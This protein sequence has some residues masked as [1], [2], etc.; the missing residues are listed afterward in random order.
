[1]SLSAK[2]QRALKLI[3]SATHEDIKY[4]LRTVSGEDADTLVFVFTTPENSTEEQAIRASYLYTQS[5]RQT[6]ALQIS[7][8][9]RQS[10]IDISSQEEFVS[11]RAT[12]P[13]SAMKSN[14]DYAPPTVEFR[15]AQ[16]YIQKH[17]RDLFLMNIRDKATPQEYA[18][19]LSQATS[20]DII[21]E[22]QAQ[23]MMT[24]A[25]TFGILD[26]ASWLRGNLTC[27]LMADARLQLYTEVHDLS[28]KKKTDNPTANKPMSSSTF[29]ARPK[30]R[31]SRPQRR[32]PTDRRGSQGSRPTETSRF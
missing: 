8:E 17:Q 13:P 26:A 29:T 18:D 16:L 14:T 28:A 12:G 31:S 5:R 21:T 15:A 6:P 20:D 4:V 22:D 9:R 19:C 25:L 27:K 23:E 1:M 24:R 32:P 3:A 11:P 30:A 2:H 10:V 7:T